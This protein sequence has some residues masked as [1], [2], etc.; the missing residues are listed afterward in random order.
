MAS[1]TYTSTLGTLVMGTGNDNNAWGSN[2]N[3]D[4]FQIFEDAI[5]NP[6]TLA[7]TGG[8]L[9][10]SGTPPPAGPSQVHYAALIFTGTLSANQTLYVPDLVKFWWVNNQTAGAFYLNIQTKNT[11]PTVGSG[12]LLTLGSP[13]GGSAYTN[14]TYYNVPLTGGSGSGAVATV[15]V[16]GG[17]VST[18]SLTSGGIEYL[19]TDTGL[20]ALA[21][22]IGGTGSGFSINA[23][24]VGNKIP[25]N[26]GWQLV[27]CDGNGNILV[28]PFNFEQILMPDGSEAAP[29]YAFI[30]ASGS[31]WRRAGYEDFRFVVHNT[32]VLQITG[33]SG[34]NPNV[35]NV[36]APAVLQQGG[37]QLLPAGTEFAFAGWSAPAGFLLEYGQAVSRATY[38]NLLAAVRASFTCTFSSGSPTLSSVSINFMGLGLEGAV[39]ESATAGITGLTVSSVSSNSITMSGNA[40]AS[41]GG[42]VTCYIYPFGNGDG[43]TT[44]NLPDRRGRVLAGR[45]NMGGTAAGRLTAGGSGVTG[46]ELTAAGG[47]EVETISQGQLPDVNFTISGITL[48]DPEHTHTYTIEGA[49]GTLGTGT[50]SEASDSGNVMIYNSSLNRMV[51]NAASTGITIAS[52]GVAASGG[53]GDALVTTQPTGIT[54][55][56]IKY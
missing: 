54:N 11:T 43:S 13:T 45:D 37:I 31:G 18:V 44:F 56:I 48:D 27:M 39:L 41:S 52:Q 26:S 21:A 30:N 22:N 40:T 28:S 9:D 7:V 24:S 25:Q 49:T 12:A 47:D 6:L 29:A 34:P 19:S 4:V 42:T 46:T 5:A 2:A 55:F 14:G 8:T 16:A 17:A 38:P 1:D 33:Q 50:T 53:S 51:V 3:N 35:V 15:V 10:L 36:I 32:D 20:S 23:A